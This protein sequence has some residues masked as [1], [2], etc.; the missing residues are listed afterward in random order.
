MT[1]THFVCRLIFLVGFTSILTLTTS[2]IELTFGLER[3]TRPLNR[4]GFPS[5]EFAMMLTIALR[6]IPVLFNEM[7]KIMKAQMCRGANFT[8]GPLMQR[9]RTYLSILVPLFVNSFHRAIE[10]AEAMEVRCYQT[11]QQRS[12][13]REYPFCLRDAA[14]IGILGLLIALLVYLP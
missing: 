1:A 6:F 5:E 10:L 4:F 12:S 11:G 2:A 8:R 13:L 9:A 7:N 14:A 3:L